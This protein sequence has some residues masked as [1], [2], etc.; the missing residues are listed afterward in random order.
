MSLGTCAIGESSTTETTRNRWG[1]VT[2]KHTKDTKKI[3]EEL[4]NADSN[5]T[6]NTPG[7]AF[8]SVHSRLFSFVIFVPCRRMTGRGQLNSLAP[9][10][11]RAVF[12]P[13]ELGAIH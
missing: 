10:E 8:I 2:T 9:A 3:P 11:G 12:D 13:H 5:Y 1:R 7:F 6:Q 4:I